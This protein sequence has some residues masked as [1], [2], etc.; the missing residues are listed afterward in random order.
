MSVRGSTMTLDV[1]Q[2]NVTVTKASAKPIPEL[3]AEKM[4][5]SSALSPP[6]ATFADPSAIVFSNKKLAG[7]MGITIVVR[8][9]KI[10]NS[11]GFTI[12][13]AVVRAMRLRAGETIGVVLRRFRPSGLRN[14]RIPK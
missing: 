7:T 3:L 9:R 11:V 12:P 5:G 13:R 4:E 6:G 1:V 2:A 10:G 8:L 14:R